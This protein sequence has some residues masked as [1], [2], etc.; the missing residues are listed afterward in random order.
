MAMITHEPRREFLEALLSADVPESD[1]RYQEYRVMLDAKLQS[2][3]RAEANGR[4]AI[5]IVLGV[6]VALLLLGLSMT[7][8]RDAMRN[9]SPTVGNLLFAAMVTGA[10][11]FYYGLYRVFRYLAHDRRAVDQV[12]QEVRD[13]LLLDLQRRVD[14]L[15]RR[16]DAK[17]SESR[18]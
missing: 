6:S 1:N 10:V 3:L 4:K 14:D 18:G 2:A 12:R 17:V 5:R 16:V 7:Q 8:F 13:T 9:L 11:G 15:T